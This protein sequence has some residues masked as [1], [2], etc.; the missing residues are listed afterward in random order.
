MIIGILGIQGGFDKHNKMINSLGYETK[1]VRTPEELKTTDALIIPGGESTT[2]LN[3]FEK[4]NLRDAIVEYNKTSPIMGTCAGLIVL[5]Q[6]VDLLPVQP[7][8]LID[9]T[10]DRNAYGRQK[11]SFIAEIEVNLNNSKDM[12]EAVFIRAPK[13]I[14]SGD[15]CTVLAKYKDD[16]IMVENNSILVCTFHPELTENPMIHKYFLSKFLK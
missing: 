11:D 10:V 8:G 5:S 16:I 1:I 3:L 4:L 7:L 2:F 6:S 14:T 15:G 9:I 13:I 12:Y